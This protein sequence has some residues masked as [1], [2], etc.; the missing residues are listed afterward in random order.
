MSAK[1]SKKHLMNQTI[2]KTRLSNITVV[3][4]EPQY[5]ENIGAA[6]RCCKNMG[7]GHLICV[8]PKLLSIDNMLKMATHEA[9]DLI[10]NLKIYTRLDAALAQFHF[11]VGTTARTGR[12]RRPT[13]TPRSMASELVD[14]SQ[15]NRVALLFGSEKSGLTNRELSFCH[16]VVNIPTADMT[17]INLAQSVMILCYEVFVAGKPDVKMVPKLANSQELNG[18]YEHLKETFT[19]IGFIN[20]ENPDYW[21]NNVRKFLSRVG[22][23]SKE[24]RVIRGFCRQILWVLQGN[25]AG[26]DKKM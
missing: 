16:R 17:S 23:R 1:S 25:C 12:Q 13:D 3:L 20:H 4:N 19:Q 18:M 26:Q 22:L 11:V 15:Q 21:L 5:P 6:A 24:V 7:I 2:T 9:S 14:I 10:E 8:N